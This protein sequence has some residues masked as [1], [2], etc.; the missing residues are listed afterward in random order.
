[1]FEPNPNTF[2]LLQLNI[3]AN[4]FQNKSV[5]YQAAVS[6][7]CEEKE[8]YIYDNFSGMSGFAV[9]MDKIAGESKKCIVQTVTLDSVTEN[10]HPRLLKIDVEG[11]EL[12]VLRGAK[13]L[14][15]DNPG[16]TVILEW[17]VEGLIRE[18]GED[19]ADATLDIFKGYHCYA[20]RYMQPL[21]KLDINNHDMIKGIGC[22]CDLVFTKD[23]HLETLVDA[24]L[25]DEELLG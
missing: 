9:D 1:M 16:L 7:C 22:N 4:G 3:A 25:T 20:A 8:F 14:L 19:V 5:C 12:D 10:F 13:H 11:F 6:D 24:P 18:R 21:K 23:G 15:A 17:D 2:Q